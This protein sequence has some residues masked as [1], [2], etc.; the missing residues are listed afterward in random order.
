MN[1]MKNRFEKTNCFL[2]FIIASVFLFLYKIFFRFMDT[3]IYHILTTGKW[4][5]GNGFAKEN[6]YFIKE[7]Y[8]TV[9]QQWLYSIVLYKFYDILGELGLSI[10]GLLE[11]ALLFFLEYKF[12]RLKNLSKKYSYIGTCITLCIMGYINI[13]PQMIS[14][15]LLL[16]ELILIEKYIKTGKSGFLYLL[17]LTTLFEINFHSTFWVFHFIVLAPYIF[18]S[19]FTGLKIKFLNMEDSTFVKTEVY[20]KLIIPVLLMI[21]TLFIN[22]YGIDGI[23]CLFRSSDIKYLNIIEMQSAKIISVTSLFILVGVIAI[24]IASKYG[25]LT[26][27]N[28]CMFAGFGILLAMANRNTICFSI[29]TLYFLSE[30]FATDL[31]GKIAEY[32]EKDALIY[33]LLIAAIG[34]AFI[35]AFLRGYKCE[36]NPKHDEIF[37]PVNAVNYLK[38]NEADLSK[39]KVCTSMNSGSYFIWNGVG[40]IYIDAKTEPYCEAINKKKSIIK[41]YEYILRYANSNEIKKWLDEYDFDYIY[42]E[43]G[44]TGLARYLENTNEYELVLTGDDYD[45]E[46][47]FDSKANGEIGAKEYGFKTGEIFGNIIVPMYYLYRKN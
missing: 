22:P 21:M 33:R 30:L 18:S 14:V 28:L 40:K 13:R 35:F 7:G 46:F 20:K 4:I 47:G 23:L 32:F 8:E 39:I 36:M 5:L 37:A 9:A 44:N 15:I 26:M 1:N 2:L 45:L 42:V 10:F 3:D 24:V 31:F 17:P 25:K 27:V 12:Y 43:Y 29:A 16:L 41:E 6:V 38:E 19:I 11:F 34:A